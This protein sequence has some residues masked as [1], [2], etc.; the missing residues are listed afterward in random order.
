MP[1]A[2]LA[3]ALLP[4][5]ILEPEV[6]PQGQPAAGSARCQEAGRRKAPSPR[7]LFRVFLLTEEILERGRGRAARQGPWPAAAGPLQCKDRG[8]GRTGQP[9][10]R[11]LTEK[12]GRLQVVGA[13]RAQTT[14]VGWSVGRPARAGIFEHSDERTPLT[15]CQPAARRARH[16]RT[17][18]RHRAVRPRGPLR[19]RS[20]SGPR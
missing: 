14:L 16:C 18:A 4:R 8:C 13:L 7:L 17:A 6:Y 15:R 2:G 5:L 19:A 1:L 9:G 10:R 3:A 12:T 20:G 11:L